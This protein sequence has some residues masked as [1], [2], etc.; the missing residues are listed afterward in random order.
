MYVQ[1]TVHKCNQAS[2]K[3]SFD[4]LIEKICLFCAKKIE[5]EKK[6]T[7]MHLQLSDYLTKA[8]STV[9][10]I[11]VKHGRGCRFAGIFIHW[12][13]VG[14]SMQWRVG[15]LQLGKIK[16]S[17]IYASEICQV[18]CPVYVCGCICEHLK[19]RVDILIEL[20]RYLGNALSAVTSPEWDISYVLCSWLKL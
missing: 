4:F 17:Q 19:A 12:P 13:G 10:D 11:L 6:G 5:N 3:N 20:T 2:L 14:C 16:C 9:C 15:H 1:S 8:E 7:W 18:P